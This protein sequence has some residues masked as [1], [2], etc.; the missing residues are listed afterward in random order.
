MEWVSRELDKKK[1]ENLLL[2]NT[3]GEKRICALFVFLPD[4]VTYG[5]IW[6]GV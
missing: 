6:G 1:A 3:A 5:K 4:P 2:Q